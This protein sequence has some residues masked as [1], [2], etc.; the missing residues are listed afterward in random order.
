VS[1]T[2]GE[3]IPLGTL[4]IYGL[5]AAPVWFSFMLGSIYLIKYASD[6]LLIAPGVMG[7]VYGCSRLW[8]AVSDPIAGHLSD[9]TRS[10]LGRRR[11]WM[12]ASVLPLVGGLYLTWCPPVGLE[13]SALVAWVG[14][15]VFLFYT[16]TTIFTIPHDSFGAE[17]TSDY[18]ERTRV[19]AVKTAVAT[20]GSLAAIGGL[21]LLI[22]SDEPR[23]AAAWL[24][25]GVSCALVLFI[26][27]AVLRLRE[28]PENQG[29]G[30]QDLRQSLRDV[31]AN[32]H[33]VPLLGAFFIENLGTATLA[34]MAPFVLEYVFSMKEQTPVFIGVYFLPTLFG[35]PLWVW[36]SRRVGK[37]RLWL[38]AVGLLAFAFSGLAF[39]QQGQAWLMFT[40]A[41]IAGVGGGCGQVV[42]PSIQ[43][44][45]IDWDE[46]RTGE[47]KEG[48][49]FAVWNFMRKS[50]YGLA[51]MGSGLLLGAI[52]FVPNAE[53]SETT[54]LGMRVLFGLVPGLCYVLGFFALRR[55]RLDEAEHTEIRRE[56]DARALRAAQNVAVRK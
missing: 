20:L 45:I 32:P 36:L 22:R 29:R 5:P 54:Q 8:D 31:L 51:A 48:A 13:G 56:L 23:M 18:H 38:F 7:V 24:V 19:F 49:Y 40:L 4:L 28:R 46:L 26:G 30:G 39:V 53:Q 17:L 33:A 43:A 47:R 37:R 41:T 14:G 10:R 42:G 1:N 15:G 55:L 35:I 50:A 9:G 21:A 27:I 25:A 6:V 16:G 44:D 34:V 12:L 3:R 52:G 2:P 11:S